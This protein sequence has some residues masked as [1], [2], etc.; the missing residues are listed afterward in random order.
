MITLSVL[1]LALQYQIATS[2]VL[3][4]TTQDCKDTLYTAG[5][6]VCENGICTNPFEHGCLTAMHERLRE[7]KDFTRIRDS[8]FKKIRICNSDDYAL[9]EG[10]EDLTN[11]RRA[12]LE[13]Y[14]D[15]GEV[16]IGM[17]PWTSSLFIS[18]IFQI[19][20]TEILEVPST[21]EY[22]ITE[23]FIGAG[24]FYDRYSTLMTPQY[25]SDDGELQALF[26]ASELGGDCRGSPEPCAHVVPDMSFWEPYVKTFLDGMFHAPQKCV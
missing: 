1:V 20:L 11:C 14:F 21:I 26:Q 4:N 18:W 16:R 15:I 12:E 6:S 13:K 3:C 22:G 19:L 17:S 9:G 5:V 2:F 10:K 25:E 24:S 23:D 7:K 8:V